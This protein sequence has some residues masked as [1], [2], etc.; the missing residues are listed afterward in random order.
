MSVSPMRKFFGI[1]VL[2]AAIVGSIGVSWGSPTPIEPSPLSESESAWQSIDLSENSQRLVSRDEGETSHQVDRVSGAEKQPEITSGSSN[3]LWE[4]NPTSQFPTSQTVDRW[5]EEMAEVSSP[6]AVSQSEDVVRFNRIME[7]AIAQ[8]LPDRSLPSIL[9]AIAERLLGTPYQ[10][11]LLDKSPEEKL[12]VS[13]QGFDCVL[14]VE[15]VLAIARGIARQDYSYSTFTQEIE[16]HRYY[17]G[18]INGYCS[19]LH[20]FSEWILDNQSRGTVK[21]ITRQLGGIS[22]DKTLNF[23]SSHRQSYP[24][25]IDNEK[26][27]QCILKTEEKLATVPFYYIPTQQIKTLYSQLKPG[28]IIAVATDIKGLDVTHTGL[29]YRHSDG[30]LG[31]IHASPSGEVTIAYDLS[32][33]IKR[34]DNAIGIIVAR[35]IDP[36]PE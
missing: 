18:K 28:D 5:A 33:Y 34:V 25:L 4:P 32:R 20:Y 36:R 13:L 35:P 30:N 16:S 31:L 2:G 3:N 15:T 12:I 1:A 27:Y 9:Q 23:M 7:F 17:Q 21:N 22:L 10:A 19:R 6:L 8:N 29:V 14:F 24:Q 26:N 11:G